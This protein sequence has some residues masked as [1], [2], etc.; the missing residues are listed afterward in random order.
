MKLDYS[1][2]DWNEGQVFEHRRLCKDYEESTSK[3]C[4][5]AQSHTTI[6]SYLEKENHEVSRNLS[7]FLDRMRV[8]RL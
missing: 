6:P 4:R 2:L 8:P 5:Y 3:Y 7:L 1:L